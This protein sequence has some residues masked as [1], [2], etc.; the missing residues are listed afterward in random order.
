MSIERVLFPTDFSQAANS[1]LPHAL[2]IAKKNS[3][4]LVILHVA[5]PHEY[6]PSNPEYQ[7]LNTGNYEEYLQESMNRLSTSLE[8]R[9]DTSTTIT[10][11]GSPALGILR[12]LEENKADMIVMGTHGRS[13]I[14][15]F[16]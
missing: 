14:P 13:A 16:F 10:R 7:Y 15:H 11:D 12:F 5:T 1:A 9:L 3:S 8:P 2:E 4:E 6:D